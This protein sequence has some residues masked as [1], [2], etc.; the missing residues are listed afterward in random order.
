MNIVLFFLFWNYDKIIFFILRLVRSTKPF[1]SWL[2]VLELGPREPQGLEEVVTSSGNKEVAR[3]SLE[4]PVLE[5]SSGPG[6][7]QV[8]QFHWPQLPGVDALGT[9]RRTA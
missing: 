8:G 6:P 4:L 1:C 3:W 2:K 5:P 7:G 9:R